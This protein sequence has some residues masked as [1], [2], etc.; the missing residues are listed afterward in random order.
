M[1]PPEVVQYANLLLVPIVGLLWRISNQMAEMAA[2][3]RAHHD[4]IT[5]LERQ[6]A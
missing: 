1:M 6:S 3:Q 2:T 5:N 4:R